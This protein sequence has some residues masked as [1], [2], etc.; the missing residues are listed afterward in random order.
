MLM[1]GFASTRIPVQVRLFLA[2]AATLALIPVLYTTLQ[3]AVPKFVPAR[4]LR[5]IISETVIG[6]LIGAMGRAFFLALQFMGSAVAMFIGIGNLPGHPI[7][8]AEPSPAVTSLI[9]VTATAL[10]FIADLHLEVFRGLLAS[11]TA[12]PVSAS[13]DVQFTLIQLTDAVSKA[14]YLAL[15]ISSPFVVY[16]LVINLMFGLANKLVPQIPIY[17]ISLPFVVAGG[18]FLLYVTIGEFLR[19]FMLGFANWLTTG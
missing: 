16:A 14:F 1:P 17:F 13:V 2:I 12:L 6:V 5:L 15:Q 3:A 18:L 8:D 11:Y 9:T 19:L 4:D 10:F 7:E